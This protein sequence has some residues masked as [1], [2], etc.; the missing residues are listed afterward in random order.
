MSKQIDE[1]KRAMD[2]DLS[3]TETLSVIQQFHEA[4]SA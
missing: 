4:S 1:M 2:Q 3:N